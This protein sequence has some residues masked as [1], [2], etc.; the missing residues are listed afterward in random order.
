MMIQYT[1]GLLHQKM[2]YLW[3]AIMTAKNPA[4]AGWSSQQIEEHSKENTE[5]ENS[6]VNEQENYKD[7][8]MLLS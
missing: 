5:N 2:G 1:L 6:R 8:E 7:I 3:E 4:H